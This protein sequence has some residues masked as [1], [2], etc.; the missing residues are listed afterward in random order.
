M[1]IGDIVKPHPDFI[2]IGI[3]Y[4]IGIVLDK[5]QYKGD[6]RTYYQVLWSHLD[7]QWWRDGE[8]LPVDCNWDVV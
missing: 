7:N 3:D 4:G 8:L 2:I 5:K 1:K 6:E